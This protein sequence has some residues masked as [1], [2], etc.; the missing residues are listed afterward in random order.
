VSEGDWTHPAGHEVIVCQ[1][2]TRVAVGEF[3]RCG[4]SRT[5]V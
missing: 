2:R 3:R 5:Q 4:A 1:S